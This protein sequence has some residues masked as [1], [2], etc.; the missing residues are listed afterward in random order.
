MNEQK[1]YS[2]ITFY[3]TELDESKNAYV[4]DL[5]EYL[6]WR[7][8]NDLI[9]DFKYIRHDL[10]ISIKINKDQ[11]W[12]NDF[13]YNYVKIVNT[14]DN[15]DENFVGYYFITKTTQVAPDT[16]L[17]DLKMDTI[18]SLGQSTNAGG[19]PRNFLPT[20]KVKRQHKN[21]FIKP[22]NWT[23]GSRTLYRNI[24]AQSEGI[25]PHQVKTYDNVLESADGLDWYLIYRNRE[26]TDPNQLNPPV[27]TLLC[28]NKDITIGIASQGTSKTFTADNFTAGTYYY[29]LDIDNSGG[30][31]NLTNDG[32]SIG[33]VTL[34]NVIDKCLDVSALP[35]EPNNPVIIKIEGRTLRGLV[36]YKD[37]DN[38]LKYTC[39]YNDAH[40]IWDGDVVPTEH[41]FILTLYSNAVAA[42]K[43]KGIISLGTKWTTIT[44]VT[45]SQAKFFRTSNIDYT[46]QNQQP[47]GIKSLVDQELG[48]YV[49]SNTTQ[50]LSTIDDLDR[51]D[52]KLI[53]IIKLPYCPVKYTKTNNIYDFGVNWTYTFG[54]LRYNR[55]NIPLFENKGVVL[56][57]LLAEPTLLSLNYTPSYTDNKDIKNESKLYHSDFSSYKLVYDSFSKLIKPELFNKNELPSPIIPID[58]KPTSTINSK[59]GF[60][61]NY[62][63]YGEY[64]SEEDF[65][66]IL[67]TTRNNEETILNNEY[68]NY[69]KTGYNY[70]KKAQA[71]QVEQAQRSAAA[72]TIGSVGAIVAGLVDVA[73]GTKALGAGMIASGVA[74]LAGSANAWANVQKTIDANNNSMESKLAQLRAQSTSTSG[75]DDVDLMSWYSDNRLH[76]M[77]YRPTDLV[78]NQLYHVFD[79]TGYVDNNT[80]TPDVDSRIWYNYIQCSP[81]LDFDR[82]KGYKQEWLDDL[83]NK[84]NNGVTVYHHNLVSGNLFR[85]NFDQQWENWEKWIVE[86]VN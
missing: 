2:T 14:L 86:G 28:A 74:G 76:E 1:T 77:I 83:K 82:T 38:T 31:F 36:I 19:N 56:T 32:D 35:L 49:G 8:V 42:I 54:L 48:I 59:F 12:V 63:D 26:Q 65:G 10:V 84:Y 61:L 79:L 81:E 58:F 6:N 62:S 24:D 78:L 9:N 45:F 33:Y 11:K 17:V 43:D 69:I 34:G 64:K 44:S 37:T 50:T 4:D 47:E 57:S 70:D 80:W 3:K 71:L 67:L 21:R 27:D 22:T 5:E 30:R 75:T 18:N 40:L 39:I 15:T 55:N 51:T 20:T 46:E 25:I 72:T 7:P 68:L 41:N 66:D 60:K 16:I 23:P 73:I 13:N 29:F 53:K 85:W 52:S